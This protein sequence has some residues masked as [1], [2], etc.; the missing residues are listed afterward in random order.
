MQKK[1]IGMLFLATLLLASNVSAETA[2]LNFNDYSTPENQYM[3]VLVDGSLYSEGTPIAEYTGL[4]YDGTTGGGQLSATGLTIHDVLLAPNTDGSLHV[5]GLLDFSGSTYNVFGDMAVECYWDSES[6]VTSFSFWALDR[7]ADG[8]VGLDLLLT[9][10]AYAGVTATLDF[11]GETHLLAYVDNPF[12]TYNPVPE[13]ASLFLI[14][15][16]IAGLVGLRKRK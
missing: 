1:I 11:R 3:N 4:W 2:W 16:G 7:D 9:D 15:T 12:P 6:D 13:P 10:P 8:M 14:G 5:T